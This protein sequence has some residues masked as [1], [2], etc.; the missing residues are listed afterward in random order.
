MSRPIRRLLFDARCV[1]VLQTVWSA[2]LGPGVRRKKRVLYIAL[3]DVLKDTRRSAFP[4]TFAV[5]GCTLFQF[6]MATY[7]SLL[8]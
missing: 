6:Q 2:R 7:R 8:F 5:Q 3:T 1:F 4:S